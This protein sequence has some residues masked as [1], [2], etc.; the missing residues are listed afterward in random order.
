MRSEEEEGG[1]GKAYIYCFYDVILVLESVQGGEGVW[2]ST[3][4]SY[5]LYGWSLFKVL[6]MGMSLYPSLKFGICDISY[7]ICFKQI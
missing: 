2:K 1:Q 6:R 4:L 7:T 3:N 5:V